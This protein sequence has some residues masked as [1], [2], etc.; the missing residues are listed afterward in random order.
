MSRNLW[1][2]AESTGKRRKRSRLQAL[3][4]RQ[5]PDEA[6]TGGM[7][8]TELDL[9]TLARS[10]GDDIT[11]LFSQIIT[12]NFAMIVAIFYFL[13][14]AK[15]PIEVFAYI[16]YGVGMLVFFGRALEQTSLLYGTLQQLRAL[17]HPSYLTQQFIGLQGTWLGIG[18]SAL[19][20]IAY[21]LLWLG[22]TYLLFVWKKEEH[23]K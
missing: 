3:A 9:L 18:T 7:P 12:I 15:L 10:M 6:A 17:P 21:W 13:N 20:N 23:V 22:V 19:F 5:R 2:L 14:Q 1:G 4:S 11:A 8:M 16:A